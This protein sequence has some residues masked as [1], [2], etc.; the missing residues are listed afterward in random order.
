MNDFDLKAKL[1]GFFKSFVS[2]NSFPISIDK[3]R[4][5]SAKSA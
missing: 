1:H 3:D 5:A 2:S 4:A